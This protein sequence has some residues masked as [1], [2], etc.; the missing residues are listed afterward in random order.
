VHNLKV[1]VK[2][3]GGFIAVILVFSIT[4]VLS[5][6]RSSRIVADYT[7]LIDVTFTTHVDTVKLDGDLSSMESGVRGVILTGS[8]ASVQEFQTALTD[9]QATETALS[10]LVSTA[11]ELAAYQTVKSQLDP[12]VSSLQQELQEAKAGKTKTAAAALDAQATARAQLSTAIQALR[13]LAQQREG[14]VKAADAAAAAGTEHLQVILGSLAAA[15]GLLLALLISAGI[16]RPL[17]ALVALATKVA[18]GDLRV[19]DVEVRGSDEVALLSGAFNAML[20]SLRGVI[21]RVTEASQQVAAASEQLTASADQTSRAVEQVATTI[22][23]VAEGATTQTR[24]VTGTA[25][26][27]DELKQAIT[28]I[29]RGAEQQGSGIAAAGRDVSGSATAVKQVAENAQ[30]VSSMAGQA[31]AS[32]REGGDAVRA[33]IEGMGRIRTTVLSS[34]EKVQE[35]GAHSQQIGE[36]TQVISDISDQ[37]NLLALNAAIEAARAGEHGKGFAVVADAV[38]QLAERSSKAAK[39]ISQL[40]GSIQSGTQAAVAAMQEGT[41]EVEDGA[42]L[43]GRAG[44]ALQQILAAMERTQSQVQAIATAA[45]QMAGRS[46]EVVK[47]MQNVG[48]VTEQNTAATQQMAASADQVHESVQQVAATSQ[49]SAAA[50][51]E[52]SASAE[53]MSAATEQIAAS[54]RTLAQMAQDLQAA[55]AHFQLKGAA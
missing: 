3:L 39:E 34:A 12:M 13:T 23:Q 22:S 21:L 52:V 15:L 36:I 30:E 29:A 14:S 42:R 25:Q 35:L 50:A 4:T 49:Q 43:A 48:A 6:V 26:A 1:G 19:Q 53:E 55:V 47:T 5:I 18:G 51:E 33:T 37:T 28:Q 31:L 7:R 41:R 44:E 9:A 11:Q 32:G 45:E 27:V 17:S 38:R 40:I 24:S 10:G 54:S 2:L 16:T 46:G 8:A 20:G